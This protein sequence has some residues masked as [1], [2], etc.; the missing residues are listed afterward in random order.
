MRSVRQVRCDLARPPG[1]ARGWPA[2]A[3]R[4]APHFSSAAHAH[5]QGRSIP[6]GNALRWARRR[7]ACPYR[8]GCSSPRRP[9]IPPRSVF[10]FVFAVVGVIETANGLAILLDE[11][12][13]VELGVNHHGIGRGVTE[14]RLNNVHGRV[15]V[16]MLGL[17]DAPAIVRQQNERRTVRTAG[18]LQT[19]EISRTR[20]RIV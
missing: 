7:G 3:E 19:I 4:S 2:C 11:L 12:T 6:S 16:Q 14:Q 8:A 5:S 17:R 18:F 10:Q 1:C 15:V 13:G 9:P 20:V